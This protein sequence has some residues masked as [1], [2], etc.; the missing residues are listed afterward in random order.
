MLT[1]SEIEQFRSDS[2][3]EENLGAL[4][5]IEIEMNKYKTLLNTDPW[6]KEYAR[7]DE[8]YEKMKIMNKSNN[9]I[10]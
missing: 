8:S 7:L 3:M 9:G 4:K 2:M 10:E 1:D 6:L 5:E